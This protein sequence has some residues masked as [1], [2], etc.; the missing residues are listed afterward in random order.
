MIYKSYIQNYSTVASHTNI[1]HFRKKKEMCCQPLGKSLTS[2]FFNIEYSGRGKHNNI[3][4]K[5]HEEQEDKVLFS[6]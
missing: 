2:I 5:S 3:Y 6:L 1:F 4:P